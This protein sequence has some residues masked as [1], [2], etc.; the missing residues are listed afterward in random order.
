MLMALPLLPADQMEEGL[1]IT[2]AKAV[3]LNVNT[4]EFEQLCERIANHWFSAVGV[5]I[6]SVHGRVT[7]TNNGLESTFRALNAAF[8][9]AHPNVWN[10][11]GKL[12]MFPN[13]FC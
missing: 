6:L 2:R 9:N 13:F 7:R 8:P 4:P 3:T 5:E 12:Y 1:Q 11:L 10:L